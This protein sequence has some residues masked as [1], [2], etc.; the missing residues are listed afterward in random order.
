MQQLAVIQAAES[1]AERDAQYDRLAGMLAA[2]GV[3][4]S[5]VAAASFDAALTDLVDES[6]ESSVRRAA[7]QKIGALREQATAADVARVV[8]ALSN[9]HDCDVGGGAISVRRA[10]LLAF[11]ELARA[12]DGGVLA[13]VASC[14]PAVSALL[15]HAD[16]DAR[17]MAARAASALGPHADAVSLAA[18][19][20]D[21][22]PDVRSAAADTL[23]VLRG[24]LS[25]GAV[26]AIAERVRH[27]DEEVRAAA[28]Q[29]LGGIGTA[30][31]PHVGLVA[32]CMVDDDAATA[33]RVAAIRALAALGGGAQGG[34]AGG[35][36]TYTLR[37]SGLLEE[38]EA[39]VRVAA[40]EALGLLLPEPAGCAD[41]VSEL[42]GDPD[43]AVRGAAT[44]ALKRWGLA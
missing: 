36:P 5:P 11:T 38:E 17:E 18:L 32:A 16:A 40:V 33:T 21:D 14:A 6:A 8:E 41:A 12:P 29:T 34:T 25:A 2:N 42:L 7:A 4:T 20:E 22:E 28:L 26:E 19:L 24:A 44:A 15:G 23:V 43:R 3:D 27:D 37:I 30:A 13:A 31:A 35:G 1:D 39:A 9:P 10:A